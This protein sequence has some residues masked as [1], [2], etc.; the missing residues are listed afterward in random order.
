ME[1]GQLVAE[2]EGEGG[3]RGEAQGDGDA[4]VG[5]RVGEP[6][7]RERRRRGSCGGARRRGR[8][9][10][11]P[12]LTYLVFYTNNYNTIKITTIKKKLV[13]IAHLG[14]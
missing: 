3:V 10:L 2:Q 11:F 4:E 8:R 12:R 5:E 14:D 7:A 6:A 9:I 13:L 1:G